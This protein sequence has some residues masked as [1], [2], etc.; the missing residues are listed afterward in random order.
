MVLAAITV[1]GFQTQSL[2]NGDAQ[3][4]ICSFVLTPAAHARILKDW[5]ETQKQQWELE[6][7]NENMTHKSFLSSGTELLPRHREERGERAPVL[8]D[9]GLRGGEPEAPSESTWCLSM[10]LWWGCLNPSAQTYVRHKTISVW[11]GERKVRRK[12]VVFPQLTAI[13]HVELLLASCVDKNTRVQEET[14]HV[15]QIQPHPTVPP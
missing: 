14:H 3:D 8:K 1:F 9:T 4:F 11:V 13:R 2:A 5:Y 7:L 15:P 6:S 12:H 10:D